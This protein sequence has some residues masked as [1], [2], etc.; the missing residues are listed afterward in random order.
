MLPLAT[1]REKGTKKRALADEALARV[2]LAGKGDRLPAQ[3]SGGEQWLTVFGAVG[4]AGHV[5]AV[6]K[7]GTEME[8]LPYTALQIA[9]VTVGYRLYDSSGNLLPSSTPGQMQSDFQILMTQ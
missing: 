8:V 4:Y 2:G 6:S 7:F 9:T 3:I 1:G 5:L